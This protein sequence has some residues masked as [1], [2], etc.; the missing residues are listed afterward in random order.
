MADRGAAHGQEAHGEP[1]GETSPR[2]DSGKAL[3]VG[4]DE[5][6]CSVAGRMLR[7]LGCQVGFG[8]DADEAVHEYAG[9]R[10]AGRPYDL[11]IMDLRLAGGANG[12]DAM[13][14][15]RRIDPRTRAR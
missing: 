1:A 10:S 3:V 5:M 15:V 11:V 2:R 6:V 12:T 9:A 7:H 4:D 13:Q 14:R 8:R